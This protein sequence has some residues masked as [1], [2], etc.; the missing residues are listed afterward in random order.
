MAHQGESADVEFAN[1]VDAPHRA[2]A[3]WHALPVSCVCVSVNKCAGD[4][5]EDLP[6]RK[7]WC[8]KMPE[9]PAM[10]IPLTRT[11]PAWPRK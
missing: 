10:R 2:V 9:A 3:I 11:Q 4:A 1:V 5:W 6:W 8:L 7:S